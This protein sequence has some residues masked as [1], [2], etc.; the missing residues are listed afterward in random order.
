MGN[1][2]SCPKCNRKGRLEMCPVK[3]RSYI[4]PERTTTSYEIAG[5]AKGIFR[6]CPSSCGACGGNEWVPKQT[7]TSDRDSILCD[8][9]NGKGDLSWV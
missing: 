7:M 3:K 1:R 5:G 6:P 2:I 9:C 8:L 4:P